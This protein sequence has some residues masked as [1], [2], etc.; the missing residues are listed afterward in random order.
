VISDERTDGNIIDVEWEDVT[1]LDP[2]KIKWLTCSAVVAAT[3][4]F[5]GLFVAEA[6]E[7]AVKLIPMVKP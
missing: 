6:Y 1:T 4:V 3:L 2:P 5:M 7:L